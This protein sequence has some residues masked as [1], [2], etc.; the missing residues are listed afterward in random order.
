MFIELNVMIAVDVIIVKPYVVP[1]CTVVEN[2]PNL[3]ML[4]SVRQRA[5][6]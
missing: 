4:I 1:S 3:R 6:V 2:L 5:L